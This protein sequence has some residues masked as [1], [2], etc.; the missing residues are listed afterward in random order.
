MND[1]NFRICDIEFIPM[2]AFNDNIYSLYKSILSIFCKEYYIQIINE[3]NDNDNEN[4][5]ENYINDIINDIIN[6]YGV[7]NIGSNNDILQK[8]IFYLIENFN[9][10]KNELKNI[11][12]I[13]LIKYTISSNVI[14][15][16]LCDLLKIN[17]IIIDTDEN[18]KIF[19]TNYDNKIYIIIGKDIDKEMYIPLKPKYMNINFDLFSYEYFINLYNLIKNNV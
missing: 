1:Y 7:N 16:Y 14:C 15:K 9:K 11:L 4:D 19:N 8:F 17:I 18:I 13:Q 3:N 2:C 5:N 10:N 12:S 6:E